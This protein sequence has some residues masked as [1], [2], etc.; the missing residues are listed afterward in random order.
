MYELNDTNFKETIQNSTIPVIVDFWAPWCGHCRVMLPIIE[1]LAKEYEGKIKICK[2][3][4][5]EG[6]GTPMEFGIKGIPTIILFKNGQQVEQLTGARP[7]S[8]LVSKFDA[9]I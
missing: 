4:V 8:E 6:P 2:F 1:K 5:D 3:N 9:L 7:E